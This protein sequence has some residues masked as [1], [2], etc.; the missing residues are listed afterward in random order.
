M[1]VR[2]GGYVQNGEKRTKMGS[3]EKIWLLWGPRHPPSVGTDLRGW[4]GTTATDRYEELEQ[5]DTGAPSVRSW[6]IFGLSGF[7]PNPPTCSD[8]PHGPTPHLQRSGCRRLTVVEVVSVHLRTRAVATATAQKCFCAEGS[9]TLVLFT[10]G[11]SCNPCHLPAVPPVVPLEKRIRPPASMGAAVAAATQI[12]IIPGSPAVPVNRSTSAWFQTLNL[13]LVYRWSNRRHSEGF[14]SKLSGAAGGLEFTS[15]LRERG[16]SI[17]RLIPLAPVRAGT[18]HQP[19]GLIKCDFAA[20]THKSQPWLIMAKKTQPLQRPEAWFK[21]RRVTWK[22]K[23]LS[24]TPLNKRLRIQTP[25]LASRRMESRSRMESD[26]CLCPRYHDLRL[27][28]K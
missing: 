18:R 21:C 17:Q 1:K 4:N 20:P 7:S 15:T 25:A 2:G 24:I 22:L 9:G 10:A 28:P 23:D 8:R 14:I 16:E 11:W 27:K 13:V 12:H 19:A 6:R 5:T 26:T 3:E